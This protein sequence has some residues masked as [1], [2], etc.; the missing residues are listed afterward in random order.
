MFYNLCFVFMIFIFASF[1]GY[2][3]EIIFCSLGNKKVILNRGF[4]LGPYIP[5]YGI[6]FLIMVYML[7]PYK[8]DVF[9]FFWLTVVLCSFIEYVTSYL[10]EKIFTVRWWD[11]SKQPFNYNGRVCLKNS[12]LFGFGGLVIIYGIYPF[13]NNILLLL[14]S[15]VLEIIAVILFI[16]F[17]VDLGFTTSAL[18]NVRTNLSKFAGRD[19]TKK[20]R[21]EVLKA[22]EKHDFS[23]SRLINAFPHVENVNIKEFTA[24]KNYVLKYDRKREKIKIKQRKRDK[25]R[26]IRQKK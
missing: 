2:L 4:L 17:M 21:S 3:C 19:V 15:S 22:I 25:R 6:G 20:A 9:A 26:K 8:N 14:P 5:I 16:V 11:Y 23:F 10:M 1:L 12:M 24:F 7:S 13:I 18:L